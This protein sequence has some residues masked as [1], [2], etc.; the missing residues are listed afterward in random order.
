MKKNALFVF[1]IICILLVILALIGKLSVWAQTNETS[2]QDSSNS[3][4]EKL[5]KIEIL[6]EKIATKVAQ[7]REDEQG[8]FLGT[9]KTIDKSKLL[10]QTKDGEKTVSFSDDTSFYAF[11]SDHTKSESSINKLKPGDSLTALGYF[12]AD[13]TILSAKYVFVSTPS[14]RIIG[15]IGDIDKSN[16]SIT[17]IENQGNSII[18][19][20]KNSKLFVYTP[21]K[22][23]IKSGFSK[24]KPA[25]VIHMSAKANPTEKDRYSALQLYSLTFTSPT[26]VISAPTPT[27]TASP[28]A[29]PKATITVKPTSKQSTSSATPTTK[30]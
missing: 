29:L 18:D 17:V 20:E 9:V 10:L 7:L 14:A 13:R 3:A 23:F 28:S 5:K 8:G 11:A 30:K 6:K 26:A 1:S 27:E 22:G 25:D 2:S 12:D 21:G 4:I 15:K 19:I 24:L 16:F